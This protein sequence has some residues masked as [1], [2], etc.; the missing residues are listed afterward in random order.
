[1]RKTLTS[2]LTFTGII[3]LVI[4]LMSGY[5][6]V[7]AFIDRSRYGPGLFFADVEIF[8]AITL[9]F[10]ISGSVAL[11][12]SYRIKKNSPPENKNK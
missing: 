5:Y 7:I 3:S 4:S 2:I 1:M 12:V 11:Y 9:F 10:L 6:A 8:T